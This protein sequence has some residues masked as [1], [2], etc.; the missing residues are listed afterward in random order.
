MES[1]NDDQRPVLVND[2]HQRVGETPQQG[3]ADILVDD[4]ELSGIGAHSLDHSVNRSAETAAQTGSLV[5][6][7]VLGVEHFGAGGQGEDNWLHNG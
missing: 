7:P 5:L 6:V 1:G 4:G 3:A 2:E